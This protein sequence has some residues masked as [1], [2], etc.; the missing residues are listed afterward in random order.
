VT[1]IISHKYTTVLCWHWYCDAAV[2]NVITV[3]PV[4][5]YAIC[6]L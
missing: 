4:C 3:A 1:S 6:I 5:D 2:E